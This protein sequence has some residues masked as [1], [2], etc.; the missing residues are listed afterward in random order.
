MNVA[1]PEEAGFSV[2]RLSRIGT[3]MRGY[4]G[5]N[6]LAGLIT[7]VARHGKVVHFSA[8]NSRRSFVRPLLTDV[9][10]QPVD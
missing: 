9:C 3:V 5:Q 6:R 7:M 4:V 10:A 1:T 8:R 2:D